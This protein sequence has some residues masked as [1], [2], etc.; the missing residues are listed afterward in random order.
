MHVGV[1]E[2]GAARRRR[3]PVLSDLAL[4]AIEIAVPVAFVNLVGVLMMMG[5]F[6]VLD[7]EYPGLRLVSSRMRGLGAVGIALRA[8][9]CA[10]TS[11]RERNGVERWP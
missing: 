7:I 8:A 6:G 10:E 2:A 1:I 5:A 4:L 3:Q 9:V 11:E